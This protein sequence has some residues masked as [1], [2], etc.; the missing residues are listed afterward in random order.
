[1]A[2]RWSDAVHRWHDLTAPLRESDAPDWV[3]ELLVY[4]TLA[5]AWPIG[6]D[7]LEPYLEKALR[8]AK[9]NTSW[10]DQR[11][12]YERAAIDFCRALYADEEFL[13]VLEPFVAR[14]ERAGERAAL[15]ALALKLTAPGVPDIYQ[16]DELPYRALVD[17]DNR[18]PVDWSYRD[19]M[20][21]RL[22]GGAQVVAETRKLFLTLRLL[23]LRARRP[24]PFSAS[25][26]PLDA[27]AGACAYVRGGEVLALVAVREEAALD[28]TLADAPGGRWRD[29]L[30]GEERSFDSGQPLSRLVDE[31]GIGV[32][33]RL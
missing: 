24:R 28:A 20:L 8:E 27:G 33:E 18:R 22:M 17:P 16:G 25:Y 26:E 11:H 29:V 9:R 1:M 31:H 23:G 4:Q 3:E 19:E 13:A 21:R 2:D 30:T 5:G 15:G 32:F 14:V 6:P 10:V 12:E 7:R